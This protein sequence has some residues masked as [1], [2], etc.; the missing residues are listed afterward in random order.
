M[1]RVFVSYS[2]DSPAHSAR[3][4][5][6]AQALRDDGIDVELDQFHQDEIVDWPRWCNEQTSKDESDFVLCVATAEYRRR[7]DGRV[8]PEKG[9]GVYWEGSL[10]DDDLYDAKGNSRIIPVLFDAEPDESIPRFLRGWTFC[11]IGW[12]EGTGPICAQHPQRRSGELDPSLCSPDCGYQHVIRILTGQA[13]VTKRKL[14]PILDLSPKTVDRPQS[15]LIG[16]SRLRHGAETLFG[17]DPDLRRLDRAWR[18]TKTKKTNVL[19]IVAWGGVGKTALVA[20]WLSRLAADGWRGAQRVF[21]WSFY[22][23]GTRAE[24]DS[25]KTVSADMFIAAALAAFGDPDPQAGSPWDRGARLA[26]LVGQSRSLLVL[27]GL[28]PLQHPPGPLA[29][30]LT[31][32]ALTALLKGLAARNAGL[33]IVTTREHVADLGAAYGKTADEWRLEQLSDEAGGRLLHAQGVR[34]AG[35]ATI[36]PDD[37]ELRAASREVGG[38]ALTLTLMGKYLALALDGDIRRRDVFRF[39]E[40]DPQWKTNVRDA[41]Q[42]YGHAFKVIGAYETWLKGHAEGERRRR[43]EGEK[44]RRGDGAVQLAVLRL[45][46]LFN[47]P[48]QA[49]CLG[50]LR[51]APVIEGLTEPLV[52]LDERQWT[53]AVTRLEE[54]GLV[55]RDRGAGG[56][57]A[58]DAHPLV[59]EYFGG[60]LRE[61]HRAAWQAAHRRLYEHLTATTEPRPDTLA[62]L[63]PLYQAVA[64]G[65]LAGLHQQACADVYRDRILRGTGSDGFY[66]SKKLGAIGADLGAVACFFD[67]PW[68][69]VSPNLTPAA[70]AWLLNEAAFYLRALGRLTEAAEP[71]RASME[72]DIDRGEWKGA[73]ISASNLSQLELTRGAVAAAVT[74]GGESVTYADR[75]GDAFQR[76]SKRIAHADAL[77]QAGRTDE[78]RGLFEEAERMQAER[79]PAYP[80]LYS[81][82]GFQYCDL[83]L[84][85]TERAAWLRLTATQRGG[86]ESRNDVGSHVPALPVPALPVGSRLNE[87]SD[88]LAV[89]AAV[90]ERATQ[91]L[92]WAEQNRA[93]LLDIAL[94]HLTLARAALYRAILLQPE[95][96]NHESQI[97]NQESQIADHLA[98]AVDGL[99]AAGTFH[100]LPHALLTRAWQRK[101]CGA[102]AG[103]RADLDDAWEIAERGGMLLFQAAI[104]LTRARLF[105]R[106]AAYPWDSAPADLARARALIASCG[107]H[108]RDAE[109][110]DAAAAIG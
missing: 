55:K 41:D 89:C 66:S 63:Q 15:Q 104:H 108:R 19:S 103:S 26:G 34:R 83:L 31:D 16:A 32:P 69:A 107:Y 24:G 92:A 93:P 61:E 67:T 68:T 106:A 100:M 3:V 47:R 9:R 59:R 76:M 45:L 36:G 1:P 77:H 28:E 17:R 57:M 27:D 48:A 86:R 85:P 87:Q 8:P 82:Q 53:A 21:D 7:I 62:G 79:Q 33:C 105:H 25:D 18:A 14:G 13:R 65:C 91:T 101:L 110:A 80:R 37:D 102:D 72:M 35:E 64:H 20:E 96:S 94:D 99:R 2:H 74:A 43:G 11:R 56:S 54:I 58:L 46:G 90:T 44:G 75:S 95:I 60:R 38:H 73:A 88:L 12:N 52:G 49:G 40:A 78:A 4:L 39:G 22:S 29:G 70:Q 50:A 23:Q 10:L 81:L 42:P 97:S 109:L 30:Q 5:A 71:M 6:F 98:A 84:A 51:A